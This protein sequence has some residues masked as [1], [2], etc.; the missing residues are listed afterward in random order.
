MKAGKEQKVWEE[1]DFE[2]LVKFTSTYL[3]TMLLLNKLK[4]PMSVPVLDSSEC[5]Q[6]K[7]WCE[8]KIPERILM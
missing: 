6:A 1:K 7:S 3:I 4:S 5:G 8:V 2:I